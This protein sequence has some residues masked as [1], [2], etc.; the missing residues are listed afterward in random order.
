M[1]PDQLDARRDSGQAAVEFALVLPVLLLVI[2]AICQVGVALNCYLVVTAASRDGARRG[3]ETN[4]I[5]DA[6]RAALK[7]AEGL[8]GNPP[9]VQVACPDGRDRGDRVTVT[10][11]YRMPLLEGLGRLLPEV[12]FSRSTTM[13]L[14]RDAQ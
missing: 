1:H 6:R 12:R 11:V 7:A 10:L 8:P 5:E 4:D 2:L 14:E 13:I 9:E 3:A